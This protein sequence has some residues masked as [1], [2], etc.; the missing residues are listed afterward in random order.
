MFQRWPLL[1]NV[2]PKATRRVN[3]RR[4]AL[5][6]WKPKNITNAKSLQVINRCQNVCVNQENI[7]Q[8]YQQRTQSPTGGISSKHTWWE[9]GCAGNQEQERGNLLITHNYGKA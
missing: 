2:T 7:S 1:P 9:A 4:Q 3:I 6:L 5:Y 8:E